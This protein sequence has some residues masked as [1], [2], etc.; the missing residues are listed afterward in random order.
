MRILHV[1]SDENIGGAGILL[2]NL[3]SCFDRERIQSTV[4]LPRNSA[5]IPRLWDLDVPVLTYRHQADRMSAPA[6]MEMTQL[7]KESGAELLHAN[8]ALSA[9]LA[10]R[11]CHIPVVHTRHCCYPMRGMLRLP[12]VRWVAGLSNRWL[13]DCAIATADA[14]GENLRMLGIPQDKIRVVINGSHPVRAVEDAELEHAR[15]RYGLRRE[16]FC[17]GICARLEACKGHDTF[18]Q[19]ARLLH[20]RHAELPFRFLIVGE[21]SLRAELEARVRQTGLYEVVRFTG[22][23]KDMAPIYRL[24]RV[25]VNCSRGTETSCLALSEGMSA[26][27]ATVA[28][29]YGGNPAMLGKG[30][31]GILFPQ[32]DAKALSEALLRIATDPALEDALRQAARRRY[33]SCYTAEKM[34]EKM[35]E[36]YES[37]LQIRKARSQSLQKL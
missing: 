25:N 22:F 11:L 28:S 19:A 21:G 14:A 7:I 8:A 15:M 9:R 13:S 30:S 3:L 26:G 1:I 2:T 16:D 29:D 23:V 24:L 5:L 10:G 27:I 4:A 12:P 34:S 37:I 32:G 33:E 6:V 17:I 20:E 35:T 36:I 31:A 18:L